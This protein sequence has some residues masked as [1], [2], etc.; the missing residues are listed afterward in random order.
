VKFQILAIDAEVPDGFN[1]HGIDVET[2]RLSAKDAPLLAERY[3]G[4]AVSAVYLIRPDQ[5]VAARWSDWDESA[6]ADAIGHAIG[7][8][9]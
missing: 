7:K 3:L 8:D 6:V 9:L 1:A 2:L 4:D 5:H